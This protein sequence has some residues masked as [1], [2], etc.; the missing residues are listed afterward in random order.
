MHAPCAGPTGPPRQTGQ[1]RRRCSEHQRE[2][3]CLDPSNEN[4]HRRG[5]CRELP[6]HMGFSWDPA[7]TLHAGMQAQGLAPALADDRGEDS[8]WASDHA[9]PGMT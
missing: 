9:H 6:A 7:H 1:P 5:G 3:S 4:G 8:G 2:T